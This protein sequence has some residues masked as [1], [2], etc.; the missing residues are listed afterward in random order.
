MQAIQ[1]EN[2]SGFVK[3]PEVKD[4][5]RKYSSITYAIAFATEQKFKDVEAELQRMAIFRRKTGR[6]GIVKL[7]TVAYDYLYRLGW[8]WTPTMKIGSGC[9]VHVR[10][11]QLPTGR[12]IVKISKRLVCII[13]GIV[14]DIEDPS[15]FGKRCVY[16]Y[17]KKP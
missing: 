6:Y 15:R 1:V 12:I 11:E 13:N 14:H 2:D 7:G 5:V 16:G 8:E 4:R 3:L 17:W 10:S 9:R